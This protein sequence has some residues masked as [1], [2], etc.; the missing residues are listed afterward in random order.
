MRSCDR[1][2]TV[3]AAFKQ[4]IMAVLALAALGLPHAALAQNYP[5]KPIRL[6]SGFAPGGGVDIMARLLVPK[7]TETLGQQ[8]IIESRPGASTNIA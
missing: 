1:I 5:V 6:V 7:M 3:R 8:V 2:N 4:I